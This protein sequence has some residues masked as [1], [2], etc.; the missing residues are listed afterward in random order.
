MKEYLTWR[1]V[2]VI[3]GENVFTIF[4]NTQVHQHASAAHLPSLEFGVNPGSRISP[5][6]RN[7]A[8]KGFQIKYDDHEKVPFYT[9]KNVYSNRAIPGI[10]F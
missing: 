5:G 6:C 7:E 4:T 2:V 8:F 1:K 10:V 9:E 3:I